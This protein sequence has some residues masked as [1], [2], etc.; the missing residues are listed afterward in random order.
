MEGRVCLAVKTWAERSRLFG[1][2]N[3]S[4]ELI[5]S[6]IGNIGPVKILDMAGGTGDIALRLLD[7]ARENYADRN[8]SVLVSDINDAMLKEGRKRVRKTMY[9][10]SMSCF[11]IGCI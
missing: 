6:I 7:F 10:G 3:L 11:D 1:L 4:Q 5:S 8:T 2:T 9:H